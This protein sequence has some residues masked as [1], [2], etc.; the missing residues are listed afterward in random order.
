MLELIRVPP[1]NGLELPY[2]MKATCQG[3]SFLVAA[4]P[5]TILSLLLCG[6]PHLQGPDDGDGAGA[7]AGAGGGGGGEGV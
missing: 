4:C 2:L 6:T 1:Q 3:Y 5:P 7:G